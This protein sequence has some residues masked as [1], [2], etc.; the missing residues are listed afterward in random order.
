MSI[1][2][3]DAITQ[4]T[5]ALGTTIG[6]MLVYDRTKLRDFSDRMPSTRVA[7]S[8]KERYHRDSRHNWT[9]NDVNDIDAL[10]IAVP[11]CDAVFTDKAA[12]NNVKQS[13]ELRLFETE[14]PRRPED[15]AAWLDDLPVPPQPPGH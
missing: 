15:L 11:Y 1:E 6:E 5:L 12:R 3:I 10:S 4:A 7:A 13:R 14:L 9:L 2:L 8:I